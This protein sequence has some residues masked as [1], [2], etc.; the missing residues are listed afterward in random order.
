MERGLVREVNSYLTGLQGHRDWQKSKIC[1][2]EHR[3]FIFQD[4]ISPVESNKIVKK[5]ERFWGILV[6]QIYPEFKFYYDGHT[7]AESWPVSSKAC[8]INIPVEFLKPYIIVHEVSHGI[9]ECSRVFHSKGIREPGHGPFWSGIYAYNLKHF[10]KI[11][12]SE[13]M[14][15]N[16]IRLAEEETILKLRNHFKS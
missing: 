16:G 5:M 2:L 12:I 1:N 3:K 14:R 7:L 9:V 15:D 6:N 8:A 11:D 10:L 4:T 13:E